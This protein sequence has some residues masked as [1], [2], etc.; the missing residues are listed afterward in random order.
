MISCLDQPRT[1]YGMVAR[2]LWPQPCTTSYCNRAQPLAA[3][4][5]GICQKSYTIS[6]LDQLRVT[7]GRNNT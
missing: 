2:N 7:S 1:T 3:T 4:V 6:G 5:Y